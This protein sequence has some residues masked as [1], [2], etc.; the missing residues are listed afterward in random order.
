MTSYIRQK[1][2]C[3]R[4]KISRT[5]FQVFMQEVGAFAKLPEYLTNFHWGVGDKGGWPFVYSF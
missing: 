2:S 1:Q 5:V 3:A 4:L